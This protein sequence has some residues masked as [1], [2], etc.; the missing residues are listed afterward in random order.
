MKTK[1]TLTAAQQIAKEERRARLQEMSRKIAKMTVA[2]RAGILQANGAIM[3]IEGRALSVRNSILVLMQVPGASVVGGFR[4]WGAAGRQ[5][6]KGQKGAS[7]LIPLGT[8]SEESG[9]MTP[10]GHH[11]TSATVFDISSTCESALVLA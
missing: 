3:T 2:E 6:M 4:R 1:K 10:D 7:I 11:F 9:E 8:K 5:V